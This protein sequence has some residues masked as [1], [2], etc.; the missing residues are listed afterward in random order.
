M[1]DIHKPNFFY[2]CLKFYCD[3]CVKNC[4]RD[5]QV[6]G[7]ENIPQD[8]AVILAANHCN[9][10]LDALVVLKANPGLTVFGARA[11]IFNNPTAARIVTFLRILPMVRE[12]DGIRNV[13]KNFDTMDKVADILNDRVA[14]CFFPEGTHRPKHSILPIKKGLT[15][16][17]MVADE[18]IDPSMPLYMVPVGL[19][20][21][22]YFRFRSTGLVTFGKPIELR[23]ILHAAENKDM[24]FYRSCSAMYTEAITG[25]FTYIPDDENYDGIWALTR[26]LMA[27]ERNVRPAVHMEKNRMTV[28]RIQSLMES[29]PEEMASL[30]ADARQFDMDRKAAGVSIKSFAVTGEPAWLKS[31]LLAVSSVWIYIPLLLAGALSLPMWVL[32]EFLCKKVFKDRAFRNTARFAVM[33]GMIPVYLIV[34]LLLW[35][36]VKIWIWRIILLVLSLCS[37]PFFY[38]KLEEARIWLSDVKLLKNSKLKDR[39]ADIVSRFEKI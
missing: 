25:N 31:L 18:R 35:F 27:K 8:G 26:I 6:Q 13:V 14:F 32:A 39:L 10:L 19:E 7:T 37:Y 12:R 22:D 5:F 36:A 21:G 2:D 4:Y 34:N 28:E 9:T 11:D 15:R 38:D 30:L 33:L 3:L 29:H 23:S 20:Y 16:M 24:A 1:T 17:A